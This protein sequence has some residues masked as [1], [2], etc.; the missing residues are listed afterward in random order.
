MDTLL[1]LS[2]VILCMYASWELTF[3]RSENS[4]PKQTGQDG[5]GL[6]LAVPGVTGCSW[7]YWLFLVLLAVPGVT[8]CSWC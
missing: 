6:L 3:H 1:S 5:M 4:D 2:T 8:S 7:C